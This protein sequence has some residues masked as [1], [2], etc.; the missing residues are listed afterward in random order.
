MHKPELSGRLAKWA[1]E[2][3]WYNIEYKSRTDINSHILMDFVADFIPALV[4][5]VE[6]ELLLTLGISLGIWTLFTDSVSNVKG[7]GLGIVLKPPTGNDNG[8]IDELGGGRRSCRGEIDELDLGLEEQVHRL[9]EERLPSNPNESR[10]LRAKAARFSLDIG[11]DRLRQQKAVRWQQEIDR[12]EGKVERN[13]ARVIVGILNDFEVKYRCDPFSLLYGTEGPIPV[14]VGEPCLRFQYATE[15]SNGEAMTTS[16]DLLDKR[17]EAAS[18]WLAAQ[19]QQVGRYYNRK[20]NLRYFQVGDLV[21]R[22]VMLH[23][24]NTNDGKLGPNWEGP[25]RVA[26]ITGKGSY[27]LEFGNGVQLPNNW[28]VAHLKRYYC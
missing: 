10:A 25:Y 2:I 23:T 1:V 21:L 22:K 7:S 13:L 28:N 12:F 17:R 20:A 26:G 27:K 24:K 19:K 8:A 3:N 9:P 5:E 16:L 4:P 15:M 18:V 6:K 14:E 11:Q